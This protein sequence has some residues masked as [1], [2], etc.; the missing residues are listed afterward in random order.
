MSILLYILHL[1]FINKHYHYVFYLQQVLNVIHVYIYMCHRH[2]EPN[3]REDTVFHPLEHEINV[4]YF[5]PRWMQTLLNTRH[6]RVFFNALIK[7]HYV[8]MQDKLF[9]IVWEKLINTTP[10]EVILKKGVGTLFPYVLRETILP[11]VSKDIQSFLHLHIGPP[12]TSTTIA[13]FLKTFPRL[14][15]PEQAHYNN[16]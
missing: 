5:R 2:T 14:S 4:F 8:Y 1:F 10:A 15:A 12:L 16:T 7:Q 3:Q 11:L 6:L 13:F 9:Y